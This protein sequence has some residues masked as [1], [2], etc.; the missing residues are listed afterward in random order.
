MFIA[1]QSYCFSPDLLN[2]LKAYDLHILTEPMAIRSAM[3]DIIGMVKNWTFLGHD[4]VS[5]QFLF[6][7]SSVLNTVAKLL[8][9]SFA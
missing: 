9:I 8:C 1:M 2:R 4:A 6:H 3:T 5:P 7:F